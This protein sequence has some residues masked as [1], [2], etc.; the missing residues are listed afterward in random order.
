MKATLVALWI[1][2]LVAAFGLGRYVVPDSEAARLSSLDSFRAALDDTDELSRTHAYTAYLLDLS[3]AELPEALEALEAQRIWLTEAELRMFM[4]AWGEIDPGAGFEHVDTWP[5]NIR[6]MARAA[7]FYAW[8]YHDPDGALAALESLEARL[9][10]QQLRHQLVTGWAAREDKQGLGLWI[11]ALPKGQSRQRYTGI[12]AR[13]Y[14]RDDPDALIAWADSVAVDANDGFKATAFLKA[15]NALGHRDPLRA[16]DWVEGQLEND[17]ARRVAPVVV[18][19]WA[20]RDAKAA[21][22]WSRDLANEE[23]RDRGVANAFRE[24]VKAEPR[25]AKD[26]LRTNT[27]APDLDSAVRVVVQQTSPKSMERAMEWAERTADP[28][29]REKGVTELALRWRRQD[30]EAADAWLAEAEISDE[31]RQKIT[32][33]RKPARARPGPQRRPQRR[34]RPGAGAAEAP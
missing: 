5:V 29:K 16:R 3:A 10:R 32:E 11:E 13:A 20:Q 19:H 12:L 17:Y 14:L 21:L 6:E 2:T 25:E 28:D 4:L 23:D 24:W 33:A 18:R 15:A 26:W 9:E 8:A 22:D 34:P 30:Q 27:P 1:A 7:A 31:A